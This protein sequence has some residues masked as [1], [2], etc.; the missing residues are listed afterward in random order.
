M[1][2]GMCSINGSGFDDIDNGN[3]GNNDDNIDNGYNICSFRL[4]GGAEGSSVT[5]KLLCLQK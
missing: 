3:N 1:M 5:I 4:G 2:Q